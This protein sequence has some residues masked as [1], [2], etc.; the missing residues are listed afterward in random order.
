MFVVKKTWKDFLN[1][2]LTK[3]FKQFINGQIGL[4][5]SPFYDNSV[6]A[7]LLSFDCDKKRVANSLDRLY[8]TIRVLYKMLNGK[9]DI[10]TTNNGYHIISHH[11]VMIKGASDIVKVNHF[12]RDNIGSKVPAVDWNGSVKVTPFGRLGRAESGIYMNPIDIDHLQFRN[13]IKHMPPIKLNSD[14]HWWTDYITKHLRPD[15]SKRLSLKRLIA[16]V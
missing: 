3:H 15:L 9:C 5:V 11:P 6:N 1:D 16:N 12:L 10:V 14:P 13:K 2:F 8:D 4:Y 7:L